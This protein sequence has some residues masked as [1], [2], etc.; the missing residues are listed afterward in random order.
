[1]TKV[2]HGEPGYLALMTDIITSGIDTPDR[3]GVGCRKIFGAVLEFD[4]SEGFHAVTHRSAPPRMAM[5]ELFFFL[6]GGTRVEALQKK[7][8]HF[9]DPQSTRE[10]L[11]GRGLTQLPEGHIGKTYGFQLRHF[12]GGYDAGFNAIGGVDQIAKV[13]AEMVRDP[14]GRRHIVSMWNPQQLSEMALPPCW[15]EH[16]FNIL[17][18]ASG[19]PATLNMRVEGRSCDVL[20]GTPF[21]WQQYQV[22]QFAAAKLL[23]LKPGIMTC[24]LNDVH[25]YANQ[26]DYA[27]EA[28]EREYYGPCKIDINKPLNQLNDMLSLSWN[29][30]ELTGLQ[31]NKAPFK[32]KKPPMAA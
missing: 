4:L 13:F 9:W 26:L 16:Q 32:A 12:G 27:A 29:D 23:N 30:I 10:W 6:R 22:Y 17:P 18:D 21:N 28:I 8:I 15:Y 31:V 2:Y 11:D 25:L 20:F 19:K 5:E 24:F 3:T 14:F 1:M 7:G